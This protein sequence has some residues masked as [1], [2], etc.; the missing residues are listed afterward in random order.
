MH[1][2][3]PAEQAAIEQA[4]SQEPQPAHH[5]RLADAL[6]A[7]DAF[8]RASP[9]APLHPLTRG[10]HPVMAA[11]LTPHF[12]RPRLTDAELDKLDE[13]AYF[14]RRDRADEKAREDWEQAPEHAI[15]WSRE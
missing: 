7:V 5:D 8:Y 3:T 2:T 9:P 4:V 11:A 12:H 13:E 1:L 10:L 6:E 14:A 15:D